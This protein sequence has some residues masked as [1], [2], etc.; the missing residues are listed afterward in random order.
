MMAVDGLRMGDSISTG[1]AP[2]APGLL[3]FRRWEA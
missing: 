2:S 3:H 1:T